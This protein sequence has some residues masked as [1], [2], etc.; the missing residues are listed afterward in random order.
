MPKFGAE[1]SKNL[2]ECDEKIQKL[3]NF[4][5]QYWDCKVIDGARTLEEQRKNVAKGVSKTMH[6]KHLPDPITGKANAVDVMPY[7]FD[8]NLIEKG[9]KAKR[10]IPGVKEV[11]EAYAFSMFVNGVALGMGIELRSGAD[12]DS[13]KDF[14][15]QTFIDL[16]H[17]EIVK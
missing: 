6:S 10:D 13:D 1:S 11:I 4:V 12:W 5:I 15:D 17:H 16:P 9:L 3:F 8:W 2:A 14:N 7:P